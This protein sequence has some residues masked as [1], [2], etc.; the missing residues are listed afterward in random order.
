VEPAREEV[1][2]AM[3]QHIQNADRTDAR[4]EGGRSDPQVPRGRTARGIF[5]GVIILY[6]IIGLE[7]L[8]MISPFAAFFYAAF[9]PVLLFLAKWPALRWLSAFFL[10]HMVLPPGLFLRTVRVA[11]S[12][13]FVGGAIVFLLCAGQVYFHKLARRGPALGGLYRWIRHPQ[14]LA[15]GATGLGLAILW[16]R[17]LTIVLWTVMVGLYD[18]LARD[19]ERRM[20]AQFGDRYR[21][22]MART[23]KFLPRRLEQALSLVPLPRSPV[24]R[25]LAGFMVIAV[26]AVGGAFALRAYT[27]ARLPLW[28]SGR[29]TALAILPG[30]AIMLEHRMADVLALPEVATRLAQD[31]D[32]ILVYLVPKNYVMQGMIADTDPRWRLYEHHQTLSMIADWIFHPFRHLQ[33]GHMMMHHDPAGAS[34]PGSGTSAT[35]RRLIFL[36]VGATGAVVTPASFFAINATRVPQ[37]FVDVDIHSLVLLDV[38]DLGPGTGWGAVPTPMF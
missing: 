9:N 33:G 32:P 16:P 10:P 24:L 12:V 34:A 3:T 20:V 11:G 28:S 35:V 5:G 36:R 2:E 21:T 26:L 38:K 17:F 31:A 13:L 6:F 23:G 30:D 27:V 25:P 18:L 37:F 29:V 22:Y 14:Y 1:E 4:S 8:I 7:V 19:E 15:L